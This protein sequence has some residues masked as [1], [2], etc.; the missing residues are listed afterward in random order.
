SASVYTLIHSFCSAPG[1]HDGQYPRGALTLAPDGRLYGTTSDGGDHVSGEVFELLFDAPK[2][3]WR[4]GTVYSFGSGGDGGLPYG[5]VVVD[6]RG[7]LYGTNSVFGANGD[8]VIY[9][10]TRKQRI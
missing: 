10:L 5:G 8:G 1:C 4:E 9:K 3:K 7:N 6:I 2:E